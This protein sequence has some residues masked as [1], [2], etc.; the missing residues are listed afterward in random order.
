MTTKA[1]LEMITPLIPTSYE[2]WHHC[3]TVICEQKMTAKYID[4]RI[5]ALNSP[6]DYMTQKFVDLYGEPQRIKTLKWFERAQVAL[7]NN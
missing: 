5:K 1:K 7:Q 6:Y 4:T 3:I 2:Q